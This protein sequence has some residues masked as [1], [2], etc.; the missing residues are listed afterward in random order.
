MKGTLA[1]MAVMAILASSCSP[2]YGGTPDPAP[3]S[4]P[5]VN[6]AEQ[7]CAS[8]YHD[9]A[10]IP[11]PREMTLDPE[12][13]LLFETANLKAGRICFKGW[14]DPVSLFDFFVESMP[15]DNWKPRS[16]FK[17]G[18]YLLVYEKP[19]RD[20]IISINKGSLSTQLE[21]WVTPRL[22]EARPE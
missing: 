10:D 9:F 19:D 7:I 13:S 12:A 6:E 18:V 21:I 2:R 16:Y 8:H 15:R 14:V 5:A 11:I 1:C 22:S 4:E 20:C 17:Y 3:V